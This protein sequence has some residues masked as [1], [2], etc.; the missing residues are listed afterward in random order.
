VQRQTSLSKSDEIEPENGTSLEYQADGQCALLL[1]LL[2]GCGEK[3]EVSAGLDL[4]EQSGAD[5]RGWEN[6]Q[7][8]SVGNPECNPAEGDQCHR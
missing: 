4:A 1:L 8:A 7:N 2:M 5:D 3:L 6:G